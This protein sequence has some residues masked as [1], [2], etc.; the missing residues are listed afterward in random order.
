MSG[1]PLSRSAL[2]PLP[3]GIEVPAY[4]VAAVLPGI[5]HIGLGG[6]HRAHMARYTHDLM[7]EDGDALHWGIAGA[8]LREADTAL[9]AVLA[10]QDGLY[11]LIERE[12]ETENRVLIGSIVTAIDAAGSTDALLAA[13]DAP[14]TRIVSMTVTEN[15]YMLDRATKRLDVESPAIQRDL[16]DPQ[17][18]RTVPA[19]L[20][21]AYARRRAAGAPPFT[22][23]SCDNI[24]HNGNVLKA[25]VIAFAERRDPALARWIE[26]EARFPNSMVDRITPVPTEEQIAAFAAET[27]VDDKASLLAELFRQWVIEDDFVAGRPAWEK[28]GA[29]FVDDVTPYEFMKLRLLNGSHLAIAGLGQLSGY[30][31]IGETIED[32]LIRRY[33]AALMDK[34]TGP[35]LMPVKGIDLADYKQTLIARFANPAIRDT[36][37]RVNTD[38]PINVLVDPIRDRLAADQPIDLLSLG[39]AAWCRRVAGTGEDGQPIQVIHPMADL[40]AEKAREGGADPAPILSIRQLFGDLGQDA[41]LVRAVGGWLAS[42]YGKGIKATIA[43]AAERGLF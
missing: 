41:R 42:I 37:Q 9:L 12:G 15:G 17:H 7:G 16:A 21:E 32:P 33:M 43:E 18:P 25:A 1:M 30:T 28:V 20:T 24:Q 3:G 35:T 4:D 6:F 31:L 22:A 5:V 40:L 26:A 36:T 23:L 11:T 10:A 19:I 39:L 2:A 13:I 14:A 38:A 29:Q 34:E 8:G 27:G